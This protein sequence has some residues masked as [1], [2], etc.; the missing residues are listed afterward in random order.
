MA[1]KEAE[2][3]AKEAQQKREQEAAQARIQAELR[4]KEQ[5]LQAEQ[6]SATF[7]S[8]TLPS[9]HSPLRPLS[10]LLRRAT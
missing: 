7:P 3:A 4:A 2:L 5:A 8:S 10:S 9:L 6:V 1:A